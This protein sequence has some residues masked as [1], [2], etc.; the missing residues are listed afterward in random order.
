M[1]I[2]EIVDAALSKATDDFFHGMPEFY[3]GEEPSAYATYTV[4][5]LPQD[6]ASGISASIKYSVYVNLFTTDIAE[7]SKERVI[8]AM[9]QAGGC[10]CGGRDVE[11]ASGYPS[12]KQKALDFIFNITE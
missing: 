6:F 10:Y 3:E 7:E 11:S 4:Q 9:I 5:E 12:R 2:Y 1:S 8:S